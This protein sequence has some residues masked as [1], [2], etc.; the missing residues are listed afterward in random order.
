MPFP[1]DDETMAMIRS[2]AKVAFF[3]GAVA[4]INL[5]RNLPTPVIV[6]EIRAFA[7]EEKSGA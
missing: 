7:H 1:V 5:Q 6:R 3:A 2:Y 4:L